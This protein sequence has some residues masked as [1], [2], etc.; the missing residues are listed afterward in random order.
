MGAMERALHQ[1]ER[2]ERATAACAVD[3]HRFA[4]HRLAALPFL[5][6]DVICGV[7]P[8]VAI[9]A[10]LAEI[11]ENPEDQSLSIE[12]LLGP[13]T[14]RTLIRN[15]PQFCLPPGSAYELLSRLENITGRLSSDS[16]RLL[17]NIQSLQHS[18]DPISA[19][20]RWAP[21][22][23]FPDLLFKEIRDLHYLAADAS[24]LSDVISRHTPYEALEPPQ[25]IVHASDAFRAMLTHLQLRRKNRD[26]QNYL[27]ALNIGCVVRS[28]N[29]RSLRE[30]DH[31]SPVFISETEKITSFNLQE[32]IEWDFRLEER[33]HVAQDSLY[34]MLLQGLLSRNDGLARLATEESKLLQ[35]DLLDLE[36]QYK[37]LIEQCRS[38]CSPGGKKRF[39]AEQGGVSELRL[40]FVRHRRS[41]ILERWGDLIR[42]PVRAQE[43][44]RIEQLRYLVPTLK[45]R[46]ASGNPRLTRDAAR[47]L[48]AFL[49]STEHPAS[50]LWSIIERRA[51]SESTITIS[52]ISPARL[53]FDFELA[54]NDGTLFSDLVSNPA[55]V[56]SGSSKVPPGQRVVA[57]TKVDPEALFAVSVDEPSETVSISWLHKQSGSLIWGMFTPFLRAALASRT[58]PKLRYFAA[59]GPTA[60]DIL[61]VRDVEAL[62][63]LEIW[64][65]VDYIE[66]DISLGG[67]VLTLYADWRMLFQ[68]ERH[69]GVLMPLALWGEPIIDL[70]S[71]SVRRSNLHQL[72][73]PRIVR[74]IW[75]WIGALLAH[76]EK[77]A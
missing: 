11:S 3:L 37:L 18:A 68:R 23:D 53:L 73:K 75:D 30:R 10:R 52:G 66:C 43:E 51:L 64:E 56:F 41:Q 62:G 26:F 46:L 44:D 29:S 2:L 32:Y 58:V 9:E 42:D 55:Q 7:L 61:E 72:R 36:G 71:G 45:S 17:E 76:Y 40:E 57:F 12:P 25:S 50:G 77:N 67:K 27:D 21:L 69:V 63:N 24:L 49:R 47:Q 6:F 28:F 74:S 5:D 70:L 19:I 20:T 16:S 39:A 15:L 59:D 38:F 48:L 34:L 22:R 60:L 33:P 1:V 8:S 35:R 14:I 54:N 65:T 4:I 31:L 13:G